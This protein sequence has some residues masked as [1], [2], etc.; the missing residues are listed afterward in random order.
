MQLQ[1]IANQYVKWHTHPEIG[2]NNIIASFFFCLI[3]NFFIMNANEILLTPHF[4]FSEFNCKDGTPVPEHLHYNIRMLAG[5]LEV[6][7]GHFQ[8]PIIINSAYRTQRY[9]AKVGGVANSQHLSA[10]A[11]DISILGTPPLHI[12]TVIR[13]FMKKGLLPAGCVILYD[14]FVHYDLR[15]H[16]V[17]IDNRQCKSCQQ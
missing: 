10:N 17:E 16:I 9:N 5:C 12:F 7:R 11:V 14:T 3:F 2:R 15:G 4:K 1:P 6:L 13:S 8:L